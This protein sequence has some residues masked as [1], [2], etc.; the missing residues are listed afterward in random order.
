MR[1][2]IFP[3]LILT[4]NVL[5]IFSWNAVADLPDLNI[6][7]ILV[8]PFIVTQTF[9]P[10]ACEVVEGCVLPGTRRLLKF[11][12]LTQNIGTGNLYLGSPIGNPLFHFHTC[13]GHYHFEQFAEYRLLNSAGGLTSTGNKAGFCLEDFFP[14]VHIE[15]PV[16]IY[17]CNNQGIQAGWADY[18]G[19]EIPCQW[20]D[21][22]DVPPGVYTLEQEI[23]PA[24]LIAESDES[25]NITRM[26][27]AIDAP[28]ITP[29]R[30]DN[31]SSAQL[32][33]GATA[34]ILAGNSCASKE[35]GE[36]LHAGNA[37]GHSCWYR[38][39]APATGPV[40]ISTEGSTF[41]TLLAVYL[42]NDLSALSLEA[43][44]N[45]DG[46]DRISRVSFDATAGLE[47]SIAID[48]YNGTRPETAG[49]STGG[50]LLSINPALFAQPGFE[51]ISFVPDTGMHFS[52]NGAPGDHY[53]VQSSANLDTWSVVGKVANVTGTVPFT[54]PDVSNEARRYYR[55]LLTPSVAVP[56]AGAQVALVGVSE[57][58]WRASDVWV[59]ATQSRTVAGAKSLLT[60]GCWWD[61]SYLNPSSL[62][63]DTNGQFSAAAA[64]GFDPLGYPVQLQVAYQVPAAPGSHTVTPPVI[65]GSGDGFFLL[66]EVTGLAS[67]SPVRDSGRA[68]NWHSF[69]GNGDPNTIESIT[70]S[71]DGESAQGA[72]LAVAV[73][74]MDNNSNPDINISLPAGWTSL[75]F[76][77]VVVDNIGYRACYKLVTT[78][79]KQTVTCSWT[80]GSTFVAEAAIVVFKARE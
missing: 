21:I 30:N 52:L 63:A 45:D 19:A 16:A 73:F 32:V 66:L 64:P 46:D 56:A 5:M 9:T 51:A 62:P 71:T 25:N 39:M 6:S 20:I 7:R 40:V 24:R 59:P 1:S 68:R 58:A 8:N 60:L 79:G 29:P 15:D 37:G 18:Y 38:W 43:S 70:V 12:T 42:G 72:D 75:G 47:Y 17:D 67:A 76:N 3:K 53:E 22:T 57:Q 55:A 31:F 23:D 14:V 36:P 65:G 27:V 11:G 44:N 50:L 49:G 10:D 54:D 26:T 35:P 48:G 74:V 13:H 28:C 80:D 78:P 69:F 77:D 2:P 61:A 33:S 41:D 4:L 34:F